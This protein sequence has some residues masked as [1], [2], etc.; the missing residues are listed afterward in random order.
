MH[1]AAFAFV[2]QFST[3]ESIYVI[4]IGSRNINGSV[5][6]LFSNAHWIGLD[7]YPGPDVDW[8]GNALDYI[9]DYTVDLVVCCEVLEHTDQWKELVAK[10]A[11]WLRPMGKLLVT[12]AGPGRKPHSHHDG[13]RLRP[14]EH[15]ENI[16]DLMLREQIE[17]SGLKPL[18]CHQLGH[19]T[20]AAAIRA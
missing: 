12:C 2:K 1:P 6:K 10:S 15:Y 19:D 11:S 17:K 5:R 20:Q 14:G 9:P 3:D 13:R 4:E 7:L 8:A 16:S 18:I